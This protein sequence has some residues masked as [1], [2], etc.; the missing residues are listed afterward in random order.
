MVAPMESKR[1][2]LNF[3]ME[4]SFLQNIKIVLLCGGTFDPFFFFVMKISFFFVEIVPER[5][6]AAP[7]CLMWSMI[8]WPESGHLQSAAKL[9]VRLMKGAHFYGSHTWDTERHGRLKRFVL[10]GH[11]GPHFQHFCVG[12]IVRRVGSL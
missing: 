8:D 11:F 6:L 2:P 5:P 4:L 9:N 1:R 7:D 12:A 3:F 10:I